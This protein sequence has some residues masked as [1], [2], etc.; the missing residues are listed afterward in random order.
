[1]RSAADRL[2]HDLIGAGVDVILDDRE[3]RP[4][5]KFAD[6]E[7][8]GFPVRIT[9]GKRGLA[10]GIVEVQSRRDAQT[11]RLVLPD[12]VPTV[13]RMLAADSPP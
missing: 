12:V 13:T 4:G 2:Y 3:Q 1:V 7:L 6:A 11:Q 5:F 10:E 8:I 9:V